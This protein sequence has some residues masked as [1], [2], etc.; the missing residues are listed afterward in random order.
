MIC[1]TN[2]FSLHVLSLNKN[3]SFFFFATTPFL[4][5]EQHKFSGSQERQNNP[6][7][8]AVRIT[9]TCL[10]MFGVI[11]STSNPL[12]ASPTVG[13]GQ[14]LHVDGDGCFFRV[15]VRVFSVCV[16]SRSLFVYS[17]L[18]QPHT[19]T[20]CTERT[21]QLCDSSPQS[22][23]IAYR[24]LYLATCVSLSMNTSRGLQYCGRLVRVRPFLCARFSHTLHLSL[25]F[26]AKMSA[27]SIC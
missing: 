16:C 12:Y 7:I 27:L 19:I 20:L 2:I 14:Q 22:P 4:V 5:Q 23:H 17:F 6:R 15:C 21:F 26:A 11:A 25:Y 18:W 9:Y 1:V 8:D 24:I 13:H 10:H 3:A